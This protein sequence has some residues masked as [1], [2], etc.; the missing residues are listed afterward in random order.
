MK[1][2]ILSILIIFLITGISYSSEI[3][4]E[5]I[6]SKKEELDIGGF[7]EESDKY[8]K[9]VF[10]DMNMGEMLNSAIKGKME[11]K[12]IFSGAINLLGS[13]IKNTFNVLGSILIIVIVHSI[14]KTISENLQNKNVSKITY[15][16]QYILI[17]TLILNNFSDIISSTKEAINNMTGFIH[18]LIPLLITLIATTGN[19]ISA[20]IMQPVI[21]VT[22]NLISNL[23]QN[24][25]VPIILIS[26]A[27]IIISK[28]SDKV[29]IG[30]LSKFLNSSVVWIIGII[31]TVFVSILSLEG[32]L[33]GSVDGLSVKV[34]K[35]AVSNFVPVVGKILG[36]TVD[37]V[38]GC[39]NILKNAVGTVGI[40]VI[41]SICLKPV[42]KL[43][44]LSASYSL[45]SAVCEPIA[46]KK[47]VELLQQIGNTFKILLA[48]ITTISVMLIIGIT[49]VMKISNSGIM[50]R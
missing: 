33:S 10:K 21:L 17:A 49:L 36:D 12:S 35:S 37:T 4:N 28:I 44:I 42:V 11:K 9:E 5:I 8:T 43:A 6:D 30:K 18:V 16:V 19:V 40:I 34:A 31:L 14:L 23:F 46:D 7:I 24:V 41:I 20:N 15:Y 1:K 3:A 38:L 50:Y 39:S 13:E 2:I 45:V 47:I 27:L 48:I 32:T 26:T 25:F 22:I 29:Q